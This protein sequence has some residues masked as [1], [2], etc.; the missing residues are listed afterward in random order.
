VVQNLPHNTDMQSRK[1]APPRRLPGLD[2]ENIM[3]KSSICRTNS[4]YFNLYVEGRYA[5]QYVS[6]FAALDG[7]RKAGENRAFFHTD[8]MNAETK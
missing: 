2:Y 5:G 3:T 7:A 8:A 1:V 6:F 4:G